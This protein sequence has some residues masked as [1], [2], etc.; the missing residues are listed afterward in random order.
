M[1]GKDRR[2][3]TRTEGRCGADRRVHGPEIREAF[4]EFMDLGLYEEMFAD[5]SPLP[6]S[7]DPNLLKKAIREGIRIGLMKNLHRHGN[8]LFELGLSKSSKYPSKE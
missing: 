6:K 7:V 4:G 3:S 8:I 2:R 1:A 5:S